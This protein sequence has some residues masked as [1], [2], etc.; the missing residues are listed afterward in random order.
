MGGV[1]GVSF[2]DLGE[3]S[4]CEDHHCRDMVAGNENGEIRFVYDGHGVKWKCAD[5]QFLPGVKGE[6]WACAELQCMTKPHGVLLSSF[7]YGQGCRATV[8]TVDAQVVADAPD[9]AV[10]YDPVEHL[11]KAPSLSCSVRASLSQPA[12]ALLGGTP[13]ALAALGRRRT[14]TGGRAFL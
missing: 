14:R 8:A 3:E 2:T 11:G 12:A 6:G 9:E 4:I 7:H 1:A 5:R 13:C 10:D